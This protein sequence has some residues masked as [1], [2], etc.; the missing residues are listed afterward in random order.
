MR[1]LISIL[2]FLLSASFYTFVN[3]FNDG[4]QFLQPFLV[5][6]LLIYFNI[7]NEWL[8]Y[9]YAFMAGMYVDSFTGVF[10]VHTFIFLLIIF[11]LRNLQLTIFSSKNFFS[12]ILLT[13]FS[14]VL[15]WSLFWLVNLVF[16]LD[17]YV[18]NSDL[19]LNILKKAPFSIL[20][21]LLLHLIFYNL[22][23]RRYDQKQSF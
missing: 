9:T 16:S 17:L 1:Y 10:A 6:I 5:T 4:S 14:F 18:F 12:I 2:I 7:E 20:A 19:W 3:M 13:I 8:Y 21:V 15:F 23:I 11:I 22:W